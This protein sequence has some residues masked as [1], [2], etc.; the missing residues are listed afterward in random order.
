MCDWVLWLQVIILI[1]LWVYFESD[2][3]ID[4]GKY[5]TGE[6]KRLNSSAGQAVNPLQQEEVPYFKELLSVILIFYEDPG[7]W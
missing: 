1:Y 7:R 5:A 3:Y 4:D 6:S 2:I